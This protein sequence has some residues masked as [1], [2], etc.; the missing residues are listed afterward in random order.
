MDELPIPHGTPLIFMLQRIRDEAH[1]FAITFHR[2]KRSAALEKS[3]LDAIPGIGPRKKK[4]LLLHFG[5]VRG[6]EGADVA[7]LM[8]V[9]GI[10]KAMAEVIYSYFH[11]R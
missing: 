11:A 4:A 9:E 3:A 5:S 2:G 7:E 10:N 1:R 8:R 6:V